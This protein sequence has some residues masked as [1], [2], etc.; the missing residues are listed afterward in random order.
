MEILPG[1][2][3]RLQWGVPAGRRDPLTH[4]PLHDDLLISAALCAVLDD[5]A[6]G[7]ARSSVIQA[8][9]PLE[10]YKEVV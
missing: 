9:D 3:R 1:P 10:C 4:Q 7:E 8:A 5:Q 6:A 2:E